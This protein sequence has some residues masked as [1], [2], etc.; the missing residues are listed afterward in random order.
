MS[1]RRVSDYLTSQS[2]NFLEASHC[3]TALH[4]PSLSMPKKMVREVGIIC[5]HLPNI[6]ELPVG[7]ARFAFQSCLAP[8]LP[9]SQPSRK[10]NAQSSLRT[11]NHGFVN[12]LMVTFLEVGIYNENQLSTMPSF[13][14]YPLKK[15]L[16][17]GHTYGLILASK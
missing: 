13:L 5:F 3:L 2:H 11:Q 17:Q 9:L 16:L 4:T 7:G 1:I 15:G 8:I 12:W 10:R 14:L 6:T